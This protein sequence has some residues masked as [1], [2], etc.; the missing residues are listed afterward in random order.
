MSPRPAGA[1]LDSQSV[2]ERSTAHS[3]SKP[4]SDRAEVGIDFPD[5]TFWG[6]FGRD[7]RYDAGIDPEGVHIALSRAH[8]EK[9][10]VGFHIHYFLLADILNDIADGLEAGG[11]L[12]EVHREPLQAA[13]TKL[14]HA[15]RKNR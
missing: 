13:A 6:S 7:S 4:I 2:L 1:G 11:Q 3:M 5:K 8:G 9:R 15:L 14:R 10:N 12:D